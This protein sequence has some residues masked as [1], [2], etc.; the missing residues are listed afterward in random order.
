MA[1]ELG[2]DVGVRMTYKGQG[3]GAYNSGD[4]CVQKA[5]GGYLL[6]GKAPEAG[7]VCG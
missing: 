5:V 1:D 7:T 3:H 2:E 4:A 6:D